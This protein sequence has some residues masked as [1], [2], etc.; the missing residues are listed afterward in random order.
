MGYKFNQQASLA[1]FSLYFLLFGRDPKL[2][3]SIRHDVMTIISFDD[4]V[5]H[6]SLGM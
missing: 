3:T 2:L 1:F 6:V 5:I 4:L